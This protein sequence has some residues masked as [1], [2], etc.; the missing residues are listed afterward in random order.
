MPW[1]LPS[2]ALRAARDFAPAIIHAQSPFVSG[3]M[4]RRTAQHTGAQLVFTHHTRFGDYRHYLGALAGVA[5]GTLNAYLGDFWAGCAAIVAPGSALAAEIRQRLGPRRRPL[6]RVIPT[7]VDVAA[8]QALAPRDLRAAHGWPPDAVIV[9]SHGRLAAEKNVALLLEAFAVAAGSDP[10]LRLVLVGD[11][12]ARRGA[13]PLGR[14]RRTWLAASRCPVACPGWRRCPRSP[15]RTSSPSRRRPRRRAWS[16]P[17]RWPSA[18]R[19]W[20][21]PVRAWT[22][23]CATGSMACWFRRLRM[24][25]AHRLGEAIVAL[26]GDPER[27]GAMATLAR[28]GAERFDV[29]RRIDEVVALYRELLDRPG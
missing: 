14:R 1:P 19:W 24:T 12:P 29:A 10:R 3:L 16:W 22:I 18:C 20:R 21:W 13:P 26:A 11:G 9:A 5:E 4:A 23:R 27:R 25:R 28:E 2:D 17:K 6:V 15:A 8:L 7:G